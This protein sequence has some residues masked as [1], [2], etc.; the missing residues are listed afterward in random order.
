MTGP[1][2]AMSL[3]QTSRRMSFWHC[4][5]RS[6]VSSRSSQTQ[7]TGNADNSTWVKGRKFDVGHDDEE[8]LLRNESTPVI[9]GKGLAKEWVQLAALFGRLA[10][11]GHLQLPRHGRLNEKYPDIQ[12]TTLQEVLD[13]AW[14][15]RSTSQDTSL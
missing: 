12:P 14:A 9:E 5:R 6:E 8:K 4:A 13:K 1:N 3:V 7:R 11:D 2:G 10:V 15:G